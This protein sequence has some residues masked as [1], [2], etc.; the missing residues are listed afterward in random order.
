MR[1]I[2]CLAPDL[3]A[4]TLAAHADTAVFDFGTLPPTTQETPFTLANN[5]ISASFTSTTT[6]FYDSSYLDNQLQGPL[7]VVFSQNLSALSFAFDTF[8]PAMN[9]TFALFENGVPAG[10]ETLTSSGTGFNGPGFGYAHLSGVFDSVTINSTDLFGVNTMTATTIPTAT[11]P[12]PSSLLLLG[13][14]LLGAVGILRRRRGLTLSGPGGSRAQGLTLRARDPHRHAL[15][16]R[17]EA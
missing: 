12:E 2:L 13:S 5:G 7:N 11:T 10:F 6:F 16:F 4:S 3:L 8:T 17:R 9:V 15:H 1:L 14:G